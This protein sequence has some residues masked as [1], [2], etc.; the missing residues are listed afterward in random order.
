MNSLKKNILYNSIY[1]FMIMFLPFVTAP[2][3]SRVIGASGV[4][5]YSYAY[6]VAQYFVFIAM[7]GLN[8]YGNRTI[9]T[10]S[11]NRIRK[12]EIFSEI[13][14]MQVTTALFSV[15]LYILYSFF[16]EDRTSALIMI[17]YV[18]SSLFDINWFFFGTENFK[19]T[20]T[21][22]VIAK[23]ISMVLVFLLIKTAKDTY[24]Y[25][26]IMALSTL[27]S[28][29]LLWPF[30][31]KEIDFKIPKWYNIKKHYK[32]NLKLFIPVI[33]VSIYK[34]M[35]KIMLGKM[36]TTTSVG[37]YEYAEKI[38]N[39]PLLFVTALGT[40]ML[41]RIAYYYSK[42]KIQEAKKFFSISMEYVLAFANA[43]M[44]G[45]MAI[46]HDFVILYYGNDFEK[47]A[48]IINFLAI[49]TVFLAAGNVLRTQY[50]IPKKLD[51][52]YIRSAV[53][54]AIIN[55]IVNLILIPIWDTVGAA[56][57]TIIAE[58]VVFFYQLISVRKIVD[59]S[60]IFITEVQYFIVGL[61]MYVV[62]LLISSDNMLFSLIAKVCVG[63]II[64]LI[65]FVAVY[66]KKYKTVPIICFFRKNS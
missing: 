44:F 15:L 63:G 9:A 14:C 23:I 57:G 27:I 18:V 60:N 36:S 64:Y 56:I 50:L 53:Y 13:Y 17:L 5:T 29:L 28:Q 32:P 20:I 42:S 61:V 55:F 37:Y 51:K 3:L 33:A 38:Y 22:N 12:S 26:L 19:I 58:L 52:I 41:P 43:A 35:D 65:G 30:L 4:G 59:V 24:I 54:G 66:F 11:D 62:V 45:L 31:K 2:Y 46:S 49:T 16:A 39:I 10:V 47:S 1:Q 7:L 40:V 34:V 21:R 8:N 25:V 6:S 48:V